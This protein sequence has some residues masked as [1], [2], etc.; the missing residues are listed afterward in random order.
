VSAIAED[1]N[2][3]FSPPPA[4]ASSGH[5]VVFGDPFTGQLLALAS[6]VAR[7]E[8]TVLIGGPSGTGKEVLARFIHDQ[9]LRQGGRFIA[10]NCACLPESMVEDLLFGH[11]KGAF[12][13]AVARFEGFFEQ[14]D[15]GTLF[16]DEV[17]ELP[18]AVQAKLLRVLQ[19]REFTPLGSTRPQKTRFRLLAATNR[20]LKADVQAGRFREDLYYRLNI[21]PLQL[22]PLKQR[23]GDIL[24]LAR[25]LVRRHRYICGDIQLDAS[26]IEAL[27]GYDW[28]GNVR[29][30]E[31]VIQ[32]AMVV[33]DGPVLTA[34]HLG[35]ETLLP[36]DNHFSAISWA[37]AAEAPR[38]EY[39]ERIET[40]VPFAMTSDAT[41]VATV[42]EA[43][44]QAEPSLADRRAMQ[45][46]E[47]IMA[48]LKAAPTKTLAAARL[49]I[50]E[51]TLR[52]K[53][54][55]LREHG[56]MVAGT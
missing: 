37:T 5:G 3:A 14:A 13:G 39:A 26:A 40:G 22:K 32:R 54:A 43:T 1:I 49:G 36:Q 53:L 46:A 9:S 29:E 51:R 7:T 38:V 42:T 30:L 41:S 33:A 50:S 2:T 19:E 16:L 52:Y 8:V 23:P 20:N 35:L 10:F 56:L 44:S 18:L 27:H 48:T 17:G 31:N 4:E 45:E 28:P 24:P 34:D 15:G 55:R 25:A 21:F 12:T 11:E 47:L 6:R